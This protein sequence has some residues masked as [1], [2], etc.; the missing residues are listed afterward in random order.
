MD[1]QGQWQAKRFGHR[2]YKQADSSPKMA[3]KIVR[4]ALRFTVLVQGH[5]TWHAAAIF[6]GHGV[7]AEEDGTPV[8]RHVLMLTQDEGAPTRAQPCQ[9][10]SRGAKE[11]E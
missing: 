9:A 10:P 8:K 1:T 2:A 11:M 4:F 7:I 3:A 6:R 5:D